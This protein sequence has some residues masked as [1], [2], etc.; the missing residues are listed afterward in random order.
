MASLDL[1]CNL[2]LP[3]RGGRTERSGARD[4][5][6]GRASAMGWDHAQARD[7][8]FGR[9]REHGWE[10]ALIRHRRGGS[11]RGSWIGNIRRSVAQRG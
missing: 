1:E 7:Q 10:W 9:G 11:S 4:I 5:D 6:T 8:S 3:M 2:R